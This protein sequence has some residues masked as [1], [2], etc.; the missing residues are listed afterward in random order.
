MGMSRG[1]STFLACFT[2]FWLLWALVAVLCC[3]CGALRRRLKSGQEQR[4]REQCLRTMETESAECSPPLPAFC[5]PLCLSSP[6]HGPLTLPEAHWVTWPDSDRNPPCYEEAV[7][8]DDPPPSYNEV[9]ADPLHGRAVFLKPPQQ[10]AP[11]LS[12]WELQGR[13]PEPALQSGSSK[14]PAP[15]AEHGYCSLIQLPSARHWDGLGQLLSNM[16][17][18]GLLPETRTQSEFLGFSRVIGMPGFQELHEVQEGNGLDS[19]CGLRRGYP[20]LGRSTAV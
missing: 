17:H 2:G 20:M 11:P 6:S 5:P 13:D 9:L 7:L 15:S 14:P 4:L 3:L 1:T 8:M 10:R 12:P 16:D 19:G 18:R